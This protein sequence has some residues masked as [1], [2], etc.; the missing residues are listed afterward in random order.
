MNWKSYEVIEQ[1]S[2]KQIYT[3]FNRHFEKN[4][5]FAGEMHDFW[6]MM[7]IIDGSMTVSADDK[8]HTLSMG[9]LIIFKPYQLHKFNV[10]D[11]LGATVLIATFTMQ[12]TLCQK[13]DG[14]AYRLEKFQRSILKTFLQY[15]DYEI[16]HNE[17]AKAGDYWYNV[18]PFFENDNT[19]IQTAALF[20]SRI[21]LTLSDSAHTISKDKTYETEM[22]KKAL[23]VMNENIDQNLL[24]D[25]IATR[26][27]ISVSSLK[28]LFDKYAGMSVHKYFLTLK[29]K[30]ATIMLKTGLSVSEVSEKLGFSSQGYFSYCYKRETGNNPSQI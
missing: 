27:N 10:D 24:V 15:L 19:F 3:I 8:V 12:G 4:Y 14:R 2:I 25:E 1:I 20:I 23:Q 9:D 21:L 26:L 5:N 28:L 11:S 6:E 7:Y 18:L 29:I 22:F 17:Q 13:I 30:T 16:N